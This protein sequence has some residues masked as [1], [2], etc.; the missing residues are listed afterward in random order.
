MYNSIHTPVRKV[1]HLSLNVIDVLE[2]RTLHSHDLEITYEQ[3]D[4]LQYIIIM[5]LGIIGYVDLSPHHRSITHEWVEKHTIIILCS[6]SY[7]PS[8]YFNVGIFVNTAPRKFR[9]RYLFHLPLQ[10]I[11]LGLQFTY[12]EFFLNGILFLGL[13]L[14]LEI[15]D[16]S[17]L[18]ILFYPQFYIHE[19]QFLLGLYIFL[20]RFDSFALVIVFYFEVKIFDLYI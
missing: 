12:L 11:H 13:Q 10:H 19:F 4:K 2:F 7:V 5:H 8:G 16:A 6:V 15:S 9:E 3:R 18:Y 20:E 17:H 14:L 1:S